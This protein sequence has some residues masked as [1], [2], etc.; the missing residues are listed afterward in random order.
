M[1]LDLFRLDGKVA[2]VTGASRGLGAAMAVALAEPAPMSSLHASEQPADG[3]RGGRLPR[4]PAA[5]PRSL[6]A[7]LARSR[8]RRPRWSREAI[9]AFGRLDILVNN[10]GTIRRQ[11]AADHSDEDWDA[12][13]AVN[14]SSV[15]RLCRAAGRHMID[16]GEGGKIINVA[17]LL[18]V[19]GRDHRARVRRRQG[20]RRAAHQGA[21][22]R[23]GV[24]SHQRQRDRARLHGNRQHR[25]AARGRDALPADHRTDSGRPVGH[26]RR[27]SAGAVVFLASPASDYVHGHVLVVDGGW[28]GRWRRMLT[29]SDRRLPSWVLRR[30]PGGADR[31]RND[32]RRR[33]GD[34]PAGRR[35]V[36]VRSAVGRALRD[37]DGDLHARF[38]VA[39]RRFSNGGRG[40]FEMIRADIGAWLAWFIFLPTVLVNVIVNM[41]QMSA[42]VEG[43]YGAVGL[44]PPAGRVTPAGLALVTL[45][46]DGRHASSPR[47]SAAT[48]ASRRS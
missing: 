26:A 24:A 9:A 39:R 4:R 35:V 32:R 38:G 42:M 44:L 45:V 1:S 21:R 47:C 3:D 6:T 16:R 27:I 36:R 34:A 11:P 25:R 28:M 13:L 48:S 31:G 14:L 46:A 22:Q 10:A 12:V 43:A 30:R 15:F 33:R 17:S 2:L 8:R 5:G 23:V 37:P 19:S 29:R 41:S 20:R 18:V 40:M 7:D